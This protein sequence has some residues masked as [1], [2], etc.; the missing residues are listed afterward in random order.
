MLVTGVVPVHAGSLKWQDYR[1]SDTGLIVYYNTDSVSELPIREIP[2]GIPSDVA[3]EPNYESATYGIYGCV[4]SKMR[5]V[6]VKKKFGYLFFMT[7][8]SGTVPE[9]LD[10]LMITG[11]YKV[12]Q[13][14]DV[15]K[16]HIKHLDNYS[17]INDK[18]C[19]ALRADVVR[20]VSV[21]DAFKITPKHLEKWGASSRI[22]RQSKIELTADQVKEIVSFLDAKENVLDQY[23]EIT[24]DLTPSIDEEDEESDE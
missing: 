4:Q 22:T 8:Y 15:Q 20:F 12:K 11:Y 3:A 1:G 18:S 5:S 6:F 10:D 19:V 24:A 2:E 13:T 16:L 17:C 21:T 9:F 14:T 23:I 7:K